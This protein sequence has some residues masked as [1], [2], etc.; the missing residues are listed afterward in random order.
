MLKISQQI[1][2]SQLSG[3]PNIDPCSADQAPAAWRLLRISGPDK[4]TA[5][6]VQNSGFRERPVRGAK[7]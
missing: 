1:T 5:A 7:L 4:R 2:L 6:S 3:T